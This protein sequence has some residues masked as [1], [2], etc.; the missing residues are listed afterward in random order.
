M[1]TL[2]PETLAALAG[3]GLSAALEY[4]PGANSAYAALTGVQKR[5][6][7]LILLCAA[8]AGVVAA[9]CS[10]AAACWQANLDTALSAVLYAFVGSQAGYSI[11]P[12]KASQ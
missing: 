5:V 4:L 10:L 3:L 6:V 8:A 9:Q 2:S 12:K 7:L 11:W 1:Y